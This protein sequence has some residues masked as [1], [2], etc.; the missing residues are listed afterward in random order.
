MGEQGAIGDGQAWMRPTEFVSRHLPLGELVVPRAP[1]V[2]LWY[3]DLGGLWQALS[4]AL[5]DDEVTDSDLTMAQ[6]RF[7]RRFYSRTLLG[8]YLGVAGKD[9]SIL[10]GAKGKPVLDAS[11]HGDSLHFSLSKSGQ[12]LLMGVS[13]DNEIGVDLELRH[14]NPRDSRDL[15]RRFFTEPEARWLCGLD[16]AA[17]DAAFMRTWACKEAV[18]K[19]SGHGISNRFCRFAVEAASGGP[20]V[21]VSDEDHDV[22][23]WQ[24]A[25]LLP[26]PDY[27]AAVAVRQADLEIEAFS[28]QAA[29]EIT[30]DGRNQAR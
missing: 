22:S 19:A 11:R 17:R 20:P 8:A 4:S 27:L 5:G 12:S 9:V 23:G 28:L 29:P 15:A 30:P 1:L 24:L 16:N 18:A 7:A 25:L 26:E 21:V 10:R 14:R 6:L 3:F 13:G 2:H